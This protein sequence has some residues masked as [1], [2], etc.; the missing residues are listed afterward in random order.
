MAKRLKG[1]AKGTQSDTEAVCQPPPPLP[2]TEG[3]VCFG[4]WVRWLV[5]RQPQND[6]QPPPPPQWLSKR[7]VLFAQPHP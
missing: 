3:V 1:T 5:L 6:P 7:L 4:G 2:L